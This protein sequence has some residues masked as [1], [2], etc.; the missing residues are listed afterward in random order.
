MDKIVHADKPASSG[1]VVRVGVPGIEEDSD[2]VVPVEEDEWL[3]S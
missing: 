3:L 2:M 1:D